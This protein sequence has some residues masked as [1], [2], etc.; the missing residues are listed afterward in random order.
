MTCVSHVPLSLNRQHCSLG[1][2]FLRAKKWK[3]RKG[4]L[5]RTDEF[6]ENENISELKGRNKQHR[7]KE[8][9][10]QIIR[11]YLVKGRNSS[12]TLWVFSGV[13]WPDSDKAGLHPFYKMNKKK[14]QWNLRILLPRKMPREY[15]NYGMLKLSQ[16]AFKRS[17]TIALE[18]KK[19]TFFQRELLFHFYTPF[20]LP[21]LQ[22][23]RTL[24]NTEY[25]GA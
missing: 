23:A 8:A 20:L 22:T 5:A 17:T 21:T 19:R 3:L 4:R 1:N 9:N 16:L 12:H 13:I 6:A 15:T 2:L 25:C 18:H 7:S 11:P 14:S 10:E 24:Y